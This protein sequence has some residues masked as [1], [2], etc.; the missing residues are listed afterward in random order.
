MTNQKESR[1]PNSKKE[2]ECV[3][4]QTSEENSLT[5][6]MISSFKQYFPKTCFG[7]FLSMINDGCA[8]VAQQSIETRDSSCRRGTS[9][10]RIRK[11][12][13]Q[14]PAHTTTNHTSF[15]QLRSIQQVVGYIQYYTLIAMPP[16]TD[17][18]GRNLARGRERSRSRSRDRYDDEQEHVYSK[19]TTAPSTTLSSMVSSSSEILLNIN[20]IK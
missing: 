11:S 20:S 6:L 9:S 15:K 14:N 1:L 2:P 7:C 13:V 10:N 3:K 16:T 12:S 17:A 18:F 4:V 19:P 8:Q 5:R